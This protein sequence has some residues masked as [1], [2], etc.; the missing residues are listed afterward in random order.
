MFCGKGEREEFAQS[1]LAAGIP[2]PKLLERIV[3]LGM[4]RHRARDEG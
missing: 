3:G 1:A 2:Y 4:S